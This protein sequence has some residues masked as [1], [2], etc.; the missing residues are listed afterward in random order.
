ML[1]TMKGKMPRERHKWSYGRHTGFTNKIIFILM[2]N[3]AKQKDQ[4][5]SPEMAIDLGT[6][7]IWVQTVCET[8][9]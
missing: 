1:D 8:D 7:Q 6:I 9:R 2:A 3:P 4:C 5:S